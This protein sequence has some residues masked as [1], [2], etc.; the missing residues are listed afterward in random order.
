M[1]LKKSFSII[2]IIL[3]VAIVLSFPG[4][5]KKS[6]ETSEDTYVYNE[7]KLVLPQEY[8]Q[9]LDMCVLKSG[10]FRIAVTNPS[11]DASVFD[12]SDDGGSWNLVCD[13]SKSL[14]LNEDSRTNIILSD[15]NHFL[16][17]ICESVKNEDDVYSS[18]KKYYYFN[19]S[20]FTNVKINLDE[21][22]SEDFAE[23]LEHFNLNKSVEVKNGVLTGSFSQDGNLL[24]TDYLGKGYLFDTKSWDKITE[25]KISEQ[26]DEVDDI[27]NY[28]DYTIAVAS[29]G[30]LFYDYQKGNLSKESDLENSITDAISDALKHTIV[31][32]NYLF[33]RDAAL[34]FFNSSGFYKYSENEWKKI[35]E[36]EGTFLAKDGNLVTSFSA[37]DENKYYLCVTDINTLNSEIYAYSKTKRDKSSKT[38]TIWSLKKSTAV[39]HAI[40]IYKSSNKSI[41]VN[42][43]VGTGEDEATTVK[44]AISNLN[45]KLLAKDGPDI[46][47]LDQISIDNYIN[48][49]YL[50]DISDIVND[51]TK[52]NTVFENLAN[53]YNK[54]GKIYAVPSRFAI[55]IVEGDKKAVENASD[56]S[57]LISHS[58]QLKLDNSKVSV[59]EEDNFDYVA[60]YMYNASVPNLINNGEINKDAINEFCNNIQKLHTI[61]NN[62]SV[63][64]EE[65]IDNVFIGTDYFDL[66][67]KMI[68]IG[69]D[70]VSSFG[71]QFSGMNAL[72]KS[73]D[74]YSYAL[75]NS[76]AGNIFL[77]L[78]IAGINSY[79]SNKET[80]KEFIKT[81]LSKD[82]QSL[83]QND[84]AEPI[85]KDA[86]E[87][88]LNEDYDIDMDILKLK[89][90]TDDEKSEIISL[91]ESLNTPVNRDL[92]IKNIVF[93]QLA[94]SLNGSI[95]LDEAKDNIINKLELYLKE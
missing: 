88:D 38:L 51:L 91:T 5:S 76:S 41:A 54:D 32:G 93:E 57:S 47:M 2:S 9:V 1:K 62:P 4:C 7:T 27:C 69:T 85:N 83:A 40:N 31:S 16:C 66:A 82:V 14:D 20:E 61:Y 90:L 37:F 42:Y 18:E 95:S 25:Y 22:K 71:Y 92:T 75:F 26:L 68:Q 49:E 59:F 10:D 79:S 28:N 55:M 52:S 33:I 6:N 19:N 53:T 21:L 8:T 29:E 17:E 65:S 30:S 34:Y 45:T 44:D 89:S 3:I 35:N 15:E 77:P 60:E 73:N 50:V 70:Y 13:V 46:I 24:I 87:S 23:Q 81:L 86:F 11:N 72:K 63:N 64:F 58:E 80:A 78:N 36:C 43:E 67:D 39:E 74:N 56:I 48:N 84:G 94:S 12:S